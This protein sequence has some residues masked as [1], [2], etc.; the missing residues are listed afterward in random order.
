MGL[1]IASASA[2]HRTSRVEEDLGS[3]KGRKKTPPEEEPVFKLSES[4]GFQIGVHSGHAGLP[5]FEETPAAGRLS[6]ILRNG[7]ELFQRRF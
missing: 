2:L 4:P 7:G 1:A 5:P 6:Q 3:A